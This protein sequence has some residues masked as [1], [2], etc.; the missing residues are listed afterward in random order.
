MV[1]SKLPPQSG[2]RQLNPIHRKRGHK[3]FTFFKFNDWP[4]L[5]FSSMS[6][7]HFKRLSN[8]VSGT[9]LLPL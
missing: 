4:K 3:V 9:S 2:C 5:H 8:S 6:A 1:R 7:V